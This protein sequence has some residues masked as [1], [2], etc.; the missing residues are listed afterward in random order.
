MESFA[1][2][3]ERLRTKLLRL[4]KLEEIL[5]TT[6]C[7]YTAAE[8]ANLF[9]VNRRTLFRDLALL[10]E[11]GI[12]LYKEEAWTGKYRILGTYTR[13]AYRAELVAQ[14][15]INQQEF[16]NLSTCTPEDAGF[17]SALE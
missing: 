4:W 6:S 13:P 8:L 17:I 12:P 11:L 16:V 7:G 14:H 9:K 2:A 15:Y 3:N 1:L 5:L 10:E